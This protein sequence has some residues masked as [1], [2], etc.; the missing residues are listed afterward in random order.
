MNETGSYCKISQYI[1]IIDKSSG[2]YR[3]L[4]TIGCSSDREKIVNF[5]KA[6][7]QWIKDSYNQIEIDFL[8]ERQVAEQYL[9]RINQINIIGRDLLLGKIY[10]GIG[11]D[12]LNEELFK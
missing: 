10:D 4:K 5:K 8:D 9:E 7:Y 1:Q 11:F 12:I 3:V 6:A 2:K